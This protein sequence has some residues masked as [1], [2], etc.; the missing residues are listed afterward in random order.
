MLRGRGVTAL[1]RRSRDAD[2]P[3]ESLQT[4]ARV[5]RFVA[6]ELAE[7]VATNGRASWQ[8]LARESTVSL[9]DYGL[10]LRPVMPAGAPSS[11]PA[12]HCR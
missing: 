1:S 6:R 11:P 10:I 5:G 3:R 2:S 7:P 12:D 4:R 9:P 8:N